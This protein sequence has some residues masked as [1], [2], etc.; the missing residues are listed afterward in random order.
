MTKAVLNRN[1]CFKQCYYGANTG[2]FCKILRCM[3]YLPPSPIQLGLRVKVKQGCREEIEIRDVFSKKNLFWLIMFSS[4]N[5]LIFVYFLAKDSCR[6][7]EQER[8][9]KAIV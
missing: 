3:A 9:E 8:D 4:V 1:I 6:E 7:R 2:T 5:G